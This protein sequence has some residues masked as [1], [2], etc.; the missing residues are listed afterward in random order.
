MRRVDCQRH[1]HRKNLQLK[2]VV[3]ALFVVVGERFPRDDLDALVGHRGTHELLPGGA[4][5]QLQLVSLGR[6]VGQRFARWAPDIRRHGE[7]RHDTALE[8]GDS[9]HEELIEVAREDRQEVRAFERR[10]RIVFGQFEHALIER[11]PAQLTVEVAP[12]WQ[13]FVVPLKRRIKVVVIA[14]AQAGVENV[15]VDHAFI[16]ALR[17]HRM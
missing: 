7:P 12:L 8:A 14:V 16:L 5:S 17:R 3:Q 9:H 13:L 1:E 11:Q 4:V 15:V 6:N 2:I 10:Q